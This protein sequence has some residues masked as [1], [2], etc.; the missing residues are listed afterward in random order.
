M[1]DFMAQ[2]A[3]G[4]YNLW[5]I[6]DYYEGMLQRRLFVNVISRLADEG[7]AIKP[8]SSA[9]ASTEEFGPLESELDLVHVPGGSGFVS[10]Q[11]EFLEENYF[12]LL[13]HFVARL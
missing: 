12:S 13:E 7:F 2:C 11:R 3:A 9:Y 8:L 5:C 10:C 1:P 6:H 4:A